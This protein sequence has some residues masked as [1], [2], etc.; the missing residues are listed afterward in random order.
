MPGFVDNPYKY[1]KHSSVFVLS[2]R[3]EGLPTV[4]IEALALGLPVVST[5]CPSGPAEI[6]EGGKWGKLVPVG[7]PEALANAILEALND[8]R[9]KGMQRA[10]EFSLDRIVN[11]Y[12]ALI[13]ELE[14]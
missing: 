14:Q 5:D 11:K 13:Q 6:L 8:E 10:K 7:S 3:W 1:M 2:S 12:V 9:G 4:L